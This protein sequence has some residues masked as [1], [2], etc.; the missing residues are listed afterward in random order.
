MRTRELTMP[1]K[2]SRYQIKTVKYGG[3]EFIL[4]SLDGVTWSSKKNELEEIKERHEKQRQM[5]MED[6]KE[7]IKKER[8]TEAKVEEEEDLDEEDQPVRSRTK[9]IKEEVEDLDLREEGDSQE[10]DESPAPKRKPMFAGTLKKKGLKAKILRE[11]PANVEKKLAATTPGKS[12]AKKKAIVPVTTKAKQETKKGKV[13]PST[14]GL[15]TKKSLI[16]SRKK[17]ATKKPIPKKLAAKSSKAAKQKPKGAVSKP[18]KK[19]KKR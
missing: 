8:E 9:A 3:K 4:Y 16:A 11:G 14:K 7:F 13:P 2:K 12:E 18:S 5:L 15:V 6:T 19:A 17:P 1:E 10:E